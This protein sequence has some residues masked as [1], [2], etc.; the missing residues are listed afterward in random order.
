VARRLFLAAI[1]AIA[2]GAP[3]VEISD[4]WNQTLKD[5]NDTEANVVVAALCVGVAFAIGTVIII[6][7][8]RALSSFPAFPV[9]AI[10]AAVGRVAST[11]T[12]VLTASPPTVLRV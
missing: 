6:G 9:V 4:R 7:R 3:L 1:I 8:I 11:L 10:R 2:V 12:P 5:G